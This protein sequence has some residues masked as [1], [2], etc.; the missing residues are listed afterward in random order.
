MKAIPPKKDLVTLAEALGAA[1]LLTAPFW[2]AAFK[3]IGTPLDWNYMGH[4]YHNVFG[5]VHVDY[6]AAILVILFTTF[7]FWIAANNVC[8]WL[9]TAGIMGLK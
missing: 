8:V 4:M 9:L 7:I 5:F 2:L 1:M 6:I 3:R